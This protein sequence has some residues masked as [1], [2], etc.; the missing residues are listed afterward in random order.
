MNI[1]ASSN[2]QCLV[3][4]TYHGIINVWGEFFDNCRKPAT[5]DDIG[6][7]VWRD[8]SDTEYDVD[9][10]RCATISIRFSREG[11]H[12]TFSILIQTR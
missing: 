2:G 9:R 6:F 4:K 1:C 12:A 8:T 7:G 5:R 3:A 11:Q 10:E